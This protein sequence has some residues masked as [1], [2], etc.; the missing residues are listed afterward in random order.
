[1]LREDALL[2]GCNAPLGLG[3]LIVSPLIAE[4]TV[5]EEDRKVTIWSLRHIGELSNGR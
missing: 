5:E 3:Q 4:F 1:M 2:K